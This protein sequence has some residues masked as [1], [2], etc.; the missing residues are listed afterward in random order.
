M[1][2]ASGIKGCAHLVASHP[3]WLKHHAEVPAAIPSQNL[4][5]RECIVTEL[6]Q[7]NRRRGSPTHEQPHKTRCEEFLA[8]PKGRA[9]AADD[10]G[11]YGHAG[12]L[13][14]VFELRGEC[15]ER[16]AADSQVHSRYCCRGIELIGH[17]PITTQ[18]RGYSQLNKIKY[19]QGKGAANLPVNGSQKKG[20]WMIHRQ[21]SLS[22]RVASVAAHER[23]PVVDARGSKR[24]VEQ[25][26]EDGDGDGERQPTLLCAVGPISRT[27]MADAAECCTAWELAPENCP[28]RISCGELA[29]GSGGLSAIN[30]P[31]SFP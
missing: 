12:P 9:K 15:R 11:G 24:V 25:M 28:Q 6:P 19:K 18:R 22:L 27:V 30:T 2:R 26:R 8:G 20:T 13:S 14:N 10:E 17:G 5:Q 4:L 21:F 23:G 3:V 29:A 7:A 31:P 1:A 16:A